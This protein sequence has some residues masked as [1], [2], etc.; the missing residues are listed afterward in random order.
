ML[1]A[2]LAFAATAVSTQ[3]AQAKVT[4]AKA[5]WGPLTH[6]GKPA[7][8]EYAK[9][10]VGIYQ[11]QLR[12]EKVATSRPANP[13]DPADPA[14]AWPKAIDDAITGGRPHGIEVLLLVTGVPGW[15]NG[16]QSEEHPPSNT[17]AYADFITAAARRY[18]AVKRWMIWGEPNGYLF[19]G[20]AAGHFL[21]IAADK[22]RPLPRSKQGAPRLYA[23]YLD[24]A[25]RRLKAESRSNLVIGGN[26]WTSGSI[27]PLHWI[28]AMKLPSGKAPR[29]DLFGHNPYTNRKPDLKKDPQ[30]RGTAD[31][32]DLDTLGKTIDK[33]LG[34]TATRKK[35]GIF[36][37]EFTL[38][39]DHEVG[40]GVGIFVSQAEQASWIRAGMRIVRRSDRIKTLG[41]FRYQD[42][43]HPP[44]ATR[45]AHWGLVDENG[46]PKPSFQAFADG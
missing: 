21:P 14:Y 42:E 35:I 19:N 25:Y 5:I 1:L 40:G 18:P 43:P 11:V 29:M 10:G 3:P 2:A 7:M 22:G 26:T 44:G 27:R 30:A 34:R 16:G 46:N 37:S 24:A 28:R 12:W 6:A 20:Q 31:F 4:T 41:I 15:A 23:R 13:K 36:L 38:P 45:H 8:P 33:H 32:S 9:L 39:T 17:K